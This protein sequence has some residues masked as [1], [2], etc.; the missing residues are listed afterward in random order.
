MGKVDKLTREHSISYASLTKN[1]EF[2]KFV[3]N[4]YSTYIIYLFILKLH[5]IY[6][7]KAVNYVRDKSYGNNGFM[8]W[9]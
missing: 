6:L 1:Y 2:D 7:S 5:N 4:L 3:T 8:K 9:N